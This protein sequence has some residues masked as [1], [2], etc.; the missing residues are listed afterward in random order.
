MIK[1]LILRV[2]VAVTLSTLKC[3]H[4]EVCQ[5]RNDM[6]VKWKDWGLNV[7]TI[8]QHIRKKAICHGIFELVIV[9][10]AISPKDVVQLKSCNRL[11]TYRWNSIKCVRYADQSAPASAKATWISSPRVQNMSAVNASR[12]AA[13][14]WSTP[15]TFIHKRK[16]AHFSSI[17]FKMTSY[18]LQKY[19][20]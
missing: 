15:T 6:L 20:L 16:T 13:T 17:D 7:I 5:R 12:P 9:V 8:S 2:Q 10:R 14:N 11:I 19:M 3:P 18:Y 4:F 1:R